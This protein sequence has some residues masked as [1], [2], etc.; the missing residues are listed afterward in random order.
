MKRS[1]FFFGIMLICMTL[2]ACESGMS[3]SGSQVPPPN[4]GTEKGSEMRIRIIAGNLT[5]TA[6]LLDNPTTRVLVAQFPLIQDMSEL[7][8][9][10]KYYYLSG[11]LPT[12]NGRVG[13]ISNGDLMLYGSNCLVL[14]YESFST[15]YSYTRLGRID[16]PS[17]LKNALGGGAVLV[18]FDIP[19]R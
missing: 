19:E 4:P 16:D 9:N 6:T 14:F 7:N 11:N 1:L 18:T 12:D 17:G 3:Q 8:G 2:T 13:T 15:S 10:E 5:F